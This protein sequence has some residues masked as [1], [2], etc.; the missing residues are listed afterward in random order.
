MIE[1]LL[2]DTICLK[3]YISEKEYKEINRL[4]EICRNYEDIN[5]KLELDYKINEASNYN[6][7]KKEINE[8]LYYCN[9]ELVAYLGISS[10]G[11]S[12]IGEINGMSHPKIRRKGLF[13][14]L[15]QLVIDECERRKFKKVLL[16]SDGKSNSG[17]GFINSVLGEYDFSEYRMKLNNRSNIEIASSIRLR[18][19]E[20][21]DGK[22]ISRQNA[23]FFNHLEEVE[24]SLDKERE[25]NQIT[26]M[27][28]LE[29]KVIGKIKIS[30][31][32]SSAFISGVGILPDF[33]GKGF[34]K[35][36]LTE[37]IHIINTKNIY[38]IQLDVECENSTALNLYRDCGF[39]EVSVMNYYKYN[40]DSEIKD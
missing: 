4:E 35:A 14:Q 31:D 27:V 34:G 12:N 21:K 38:E 6:L 36:T 3:Q 20:E 11:G 30:Y 17:V 25:L 40:F 13:K 8:F 5:L 9:D 1:K 23:L 2:K 19:A 32:G 7:G 26:Y 33:R 15:F 18:E 16:L 29:D 39:E 10:F 28:E 22:E 24:W 37:A